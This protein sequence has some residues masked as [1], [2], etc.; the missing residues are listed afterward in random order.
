MLKR[1]REDRAWREQRE[2]IHIARVVANNEGKVAAEV[3]ASATGA[4]RQTGALTTRG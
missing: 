2:E 3:V 1:T 4:A